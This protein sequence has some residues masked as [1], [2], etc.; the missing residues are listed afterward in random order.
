MRALAIDFETANESPAS[1]CAV[2]LAWI[3]RGRVTRREYRLVRPPEMRFSPFN[4]RIHGIEPWD[5]RGCPELPDVL[6]EFLP[7]MAG[8]LLV[9][10]NASFDVTVLCATMAHYGRPVPDFDY[11]C[12]LLVARNTWPGS[13]SF[14]LGPLAGRLGITFQH[15][16]AGEDAFACAGVALAAATARGAQG[17][18]DLAHG[19]AINRG[20]V[21]RSGHAPCRSN[22]GR[23]ARRGRPPGLAGAPERG[24]V[25]GASCHETRRQPA[26][27]RSAERLS[28]MVLG[29]TGNEYEVAT[30]PA[31]GGLELACTCIG[32]RIRGRCRHA[33]A[34][35]DGEVEH[36]IS[37]NADD[38]NALRA[39]V[40]AGRLRP[41][42]S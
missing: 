1:P 21:D 25:P 5:V 3:D 20:R 14:S 32:W 37:G 28:F 22:G 30:R 29:S 35:L 12:T 8:R 15:H 42:P 39:L 33:T 10:H 27:G 24:G 16:H 7:D 34:L 38:L 18:E 17:F 26:A 36:L 23:S 31:G 2:G 19:L 40:Q 9:A 13:G 4:I 11:L 6:E 41:S